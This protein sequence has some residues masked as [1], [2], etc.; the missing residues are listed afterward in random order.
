MPTD[1]TGYMVDAGYR[2]HSI[3]AGVEYTSAQSSK[4]GSDLETSR[5]GFTAAYHFEVIPSLDTYMDAGVGRSTYHA[6]VSSFSGGVTKTSRLFSGSETDWNIGAGAIIPVYDLL[7]LRVDGRYQPTSF[8]GRATGGIVFG[9]GLV[10][11]R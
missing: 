7:K 1:L 6:D 5:Y 11:S 8:G 9:I 10:L 3:S 2:F 4:D